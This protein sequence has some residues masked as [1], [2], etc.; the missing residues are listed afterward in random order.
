MRR[1]G[2]DERLELLLLGVGRLPFLLRN[3]Q[4]LCVMD[5]HYAAGCH[6]RQGRGGVKEIVCPDLGAVEAIDV[7]G[8][9]PFVH[10]LLERRRDRRLLRVV[11]AQEDVE[12][13]CVARCELLS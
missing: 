7:E 13:S 3:Q 9:Q 12:R 5:D 4:P 6:H 2:F 1:R 8:T 10:H 11:R